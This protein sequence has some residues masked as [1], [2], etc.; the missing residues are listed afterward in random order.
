MKA[1]KLESEARRH[2]RAVE[3][4]R[5]CY[6][7]ARARA[8]GKVVDIDV[9]ACVQ[10]PG[11]TRHGSGCRS[12]YIRMHCN[13]DDIGCRNPGKSFHPEQDEHRATMRQDRNRA[14]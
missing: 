10:P 13:L 8:D 4:P 6:L 3:S 5:R 12:E 14:E 1:L 11:K 2:E 9:S 7:T